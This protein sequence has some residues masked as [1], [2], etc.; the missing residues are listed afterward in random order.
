MIST[1][2]H[3]EVPW[4]EGKSVMTLAINVFDNDSSELPL[5]ISHVS[6]VN[7]ERQVLTIKPNAK[8]M[9]ECP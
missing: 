7:L 3:P 5:K 4:T 8:G 6:F 2:F 9:A 1:V